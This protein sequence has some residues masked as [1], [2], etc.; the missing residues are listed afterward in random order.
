MQQYKAREQFQKYDS[1]YRRMLNK[2]PSEEIDASVIDAYS[3]PWL[4]GL[5]KDIAV[6]DAGCGY[7]RQLLLL[8]RLGFTNLHGI[9]ISP[10]SYR[11]ACEELR[12]LAELC[13]A[14]AFDY[15][16]EKKEAYDLIILND[17]L[18]HIPREKTLEL[19]SLLHDAL[20]ENG[21]VVIRVPNMSSLLAQ[22]SMYLDFTHVV[23]FTEFSLMQ[24]L[25]LTDFEGHQIVTQRAAIDLKTWRPWRPFN[26]LGLGRL[27][28]DFVHKA[29][30]SIRQQ[31]PKPSTYGYNLEVWSV[32]VTR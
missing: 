1:H 5:S 7:G 27:L 19:L 11:I 9:E 26:R 32:K 24:V 13:Q 4:D 28:N 17:V 31:S 8:S 15:F 23:G 25:D 2:R 30:Y 21:R 3:P 10:S 29:L 14:D 18:E 12:G 22:Y 6:L 20:R 16:P